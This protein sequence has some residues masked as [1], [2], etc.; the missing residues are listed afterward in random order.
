MNDDELMAMAEPVVLRAAQAFRRRFHHFADHND[1]AQEH[2]V[3]CWKH[4]NKLT[5]WF[6]R[7]PEATGHESQH[8][9]VKALMV[10][11]VRRGERYGRKEKARLLGYEAA[12]EWFADK[13][14]V[15]DLLP[16][17]L[18]G[19]EDGWE[20]KVA[21]GRSNGDPAEGGGRRALIADISR[22]WRIEPDPVLAML[23][24]Q[25]VP[26]TRAQVAE[27][28]GISIPTVNRR[29]SQALKRLVDFLGGPNPWR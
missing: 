1:V 28:L 6:D 19:G 25:R 27:E 9:G 18:A 21:D 11:L 8:G 3:W 20:A 13:A 29:E 15:A 5:E 22:A 17:I 16:V 26:Y 10:T 23:Y 24:D 12:D 4:L 14:V 7:D 2:R